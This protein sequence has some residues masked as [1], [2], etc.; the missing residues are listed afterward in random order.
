M[1]L[2]S[3]ISPTDLDETTIVLKILSGKP[4]SRKISSIARAQP[5]T[6]EECL[7]IPP[8]PAIKFDAANLNTCQKG[9]FHGITANTTPNGW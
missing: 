4:A 2:S 6:F 9:K 5:V 7:R 8:L 1:F 3:M